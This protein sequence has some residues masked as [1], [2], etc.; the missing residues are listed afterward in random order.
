LADAR[1]RATRLITR[2]A[3]IRAFVRAAGAIFRPVRSRATRS[4]GIR[5]A[6]TIRTVAV[7]AIAARAGRAPIALARV[8]RAAFAVG[9]ACTR[10]GAEGTLTRG[11]V[12]AFI[13][14][15]VITARLGP[16]LIAVVRA[17]AGVGATGRAAAR[18]TLTR[19]TSGAARPAVAR[20]VGTRTT[21]RAVRAAIVAVRTAC[22]ALFSVET[23]LL[24]FALRLG[25]A[26]GRPAHAATHGWA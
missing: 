4:V 16:A 2:I 1:A 14:A 21:R 12:A 9:G 26:E 20:V 18:T 17:R 11:A 23:F 8:G 25:L 15:T 13:R 24:A 7:G 5:R 3:A 22:V 6:V 10:A 19:I